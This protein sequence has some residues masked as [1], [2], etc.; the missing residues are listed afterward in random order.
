MSIADVPTAS[1]FCVDAKPETWIR[2]MR[3]L[4]MCAHRWQFHIYW[5]GKV[6]IKSE[7]ETPIERE[8]ENGINP[9]THASGC[10]QM[11]RYHNGK[12]LIC[13]INDHHSINAKRWL[14]LLSP[15]FET[16]VLDIDGDH[17]ETDFMQFTDTCY[18]GLWNEMKELTD[19]KGYQWVGVIASDVEIDDYNALKLIRKLEWLSTTTNIGQYQPSMDESSTSKYKH[20]QQDARLQSVDLVGGAISFM[21]YD[22]FSL[23]PRID[24]TVNRHGIYIDNVLS[25]ICICN[26]MH[27]IVDN[28][29]SVHYSES[30]NYSRTD[31]QNAATWANNLKKNILGME[32]ISID[33]H[34]LGFIEQNDPLITYSRENNTNDYNKT[35]KHICEEIGVHRMC[36]K[37]DNIEKT[38]KLHPIYVTF[39]SWKKR[40]G[41]LSEYWENLKRQTVQPD[42]YILWLSSDELSETDIPEE[43]LNDEMLEIHW[44]DRNVKSFKKFLTIQQCPE[45]YNVIVDDDRLYDKDMVKRLMEE[46]EK[47]GNRTIIAYYCDECNSKGQPWGGLIGE[48]STGIKW[49]NDSC[50]LYPPYTF[51]RDAFDYYGRIMLS[52]PLVS[53]ECFIMPF[54]IRYGLEIHSIASTIDDLD[55]VAPAMPYQLD[56]AMFAQ[57]MTDGRTSTNKKNQLIWDICQ[58][59]PHEFYDAYKN[60]FPNFGS[61]VNRDFIIISMTTWNK[62]IQNI[63]HIIDDIMAN[64][65]L[66]N[67]IVIN[68]CIDDFPR[69]ND[70]IGDELVR[71]IEEHQGF[72]EIN[73]LKNNTK[74]WKK[75]IPTWVKYPNALTISIDDDFKYPSIFIK[76]LYDE[77]TKNRKFYPVSGNH[78]RFFNMRC[79]CGCCSLSGMRFMGDV[80]DILNPDI[81]E[82]GSDDIFY[83]FCAQKNGNEYAQSPIQF[84]TNMQSYNAVNPYSDG[85]HI[86]L[87]A[88]NDKCV[89]SYDE[90]LKRKE[91]AEFVKKDDVLVCIFNYRLD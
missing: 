32:K 21:H 55:M 19:G 16:I 81:M 2:R 46:S 41:Y 68:L 24:Q 43:L 33:N 80:I 79:H 71:K 40:I 89:A 27:N 35:I 87:K 9:V 59:L 84:F 82:A 76:T 91:Y 47:F 5:K 42:K 65:M 44:V 25:A 57:F 49:I 23:I 38:N 18:G 88:N 85:N 64:T 39:T 75:V 29:V 69:L 61:D 58:E 77:Y 74:V 3:A 90:Y 1:A 4:P 60:T 10:F 17:I 6:D 62:R 7:L 52:K 14:K 31:R 22:M 12:F 56:T 54:I 53:D 34:E 51:P 8:Q 67:K 30:S 15:H 28:E 63:P 78:V 70:D 13:I 26:D 45:A 50:V 37:M 36:Y 83:S 72:I 20:H 66:P 86:D 11:E 73:W 48:D